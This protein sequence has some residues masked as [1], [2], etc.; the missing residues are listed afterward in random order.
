MLNK[1]SPR[2][3]HIQASPSSLG[4]IEEGN[5]SRLQHVLSKQKLFEDELRTSALAKS[6]ETNL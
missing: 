3:R 6:P 1:F 2:A 4:E 5:E